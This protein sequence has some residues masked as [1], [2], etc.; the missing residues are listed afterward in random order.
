LSRKRLEIARHLGR[1][2]VVH[3]GVA[4]CDFDTAEEAARTAGAIARSQPPGDEVII[5]IDPRL[6]TSL[7]VALTSSQ[8]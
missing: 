7:A 8:P 4:L 1:W 6:Q 3:N 2:E 5:S